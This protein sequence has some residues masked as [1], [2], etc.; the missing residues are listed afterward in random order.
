MTDAKVEAWIEAFPH[1][2][3]LP[4][5]LRP[6]RLYSVGDLYDAFDPAEPGSWTATY[7]HRTWRWFTDPLTDRP[8]QLSTPEAIAARI[9]DAAI[10]QEITAHLKELPYKVVGVMGG[11][12]ASRDDPSF[13]EVARLAR[14]LRR[15]GL[16]IVTGGGPGLMEAA[17][18]GAFMAPYENGRLEQAYGALRHSP[19][20]DADPGGWLAAACAVR[21]SLLAGDWRREPRLE[22]RNLGIPTWHYGKEPPNLFATHVGKYFYNSVRED[23]LVSVATGGLVFAP[24]AAGTVQEVF[25][26]LNLNYD[27]RPG[28]TATP[29]VFVGRDFWD[30]ARFDPKARP[31][32]AHSKPV[33]PL[34][35][36]LA[37]DG[38]FTDALLLSDDADEILAFL[39]A[40]DLEGQGRTQADARLSR[41]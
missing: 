39:E 29:M 28:E 1:R 18:F 27:L 32:G 22:S 34:V 35:E 38:G 37:R 12:D 2:S 6:T 8:R 10:E 17:N 13:L 25:Q 5:Q 14:A 16:Q 21:A 24:G 41:G 31:R 7:D 11:H 30:P 36:K 3:E 20:Y 9:H 23:G 4:F 19:S 15:R 40:A 33:Y 26:N